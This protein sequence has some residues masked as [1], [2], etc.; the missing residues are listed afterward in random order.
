MV[1]RVR[2]WLSL[3]RFR[4]TT[5]IPVALLSVA[6][7]ARPVSG[8]GTLVGAFAGFNATSQ[9]WSPDAVSERAVGLVVGAYI[10]ATT[11]LTGFSVLAEGAFTQRGGDVVDSG[12]TSVEGAVRADY[13]TVSVRAKI[14]VAA[15]PARVHLAAGPAFE[16]V[17]RSRVSPG[18]ETVLEREGRS[19]F[20][21]V[22]GAGIDVGIGTGRRVGVEGRV[23]D[24]LSDAYAGDFVSVRNRS[25]EAVVRFGIPMPR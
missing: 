18:F 14:A 19:V 1:E 15:G 13:L 21:V 17:L 12:T 23:F 22:L 7:H 4:T 2:T 6:A 24:G 10:D 9:E 16:N 25:W 8:Q 3:A 5:L 11:P 20:G